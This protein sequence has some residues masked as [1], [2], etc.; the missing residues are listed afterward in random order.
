MFSVI[1]FFLFF[2]DRYS[3]SKGP[4]M[5][6]I[7]RVGYTRRATMSRC[8]PVD[9]RLTRDFMKKAIS[10][11]VDEL[12]PM[13]IASLSLLALEVGVG[14]VLGISFCARKICGASRRRNRDRAD[15]PNDPRDL[16]EMRL[17]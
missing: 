4:C 7:Y 1:F 17:R 11:N 12:E 3:E 9:S 13:N 16:F 15:D 2:H 6:L 8:V 10:K 5:V 14:L